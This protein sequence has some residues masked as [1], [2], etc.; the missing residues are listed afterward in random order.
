MNSKQARAQQPAIDQ[1]HVLYLLQ[2]DM[3][4]YM[5]RVSPHNDRYIYTTHSYVISLFLECPDNMGLQ[6]P[7][8]ATKTK[9]LRGIQ[10]GQASSTATGPMIAGSRT[11]TP[12]SS[13]QW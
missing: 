7:S 9:V 8:A 1:A 6:C 4:D 13:C 12:C 11:Y 2:I 5:Q 3:S 10:T